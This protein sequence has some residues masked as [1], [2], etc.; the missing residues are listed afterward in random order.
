MEIPVASPTPTALQFQPASFGATPTF[1][2]VTIPT[3]KGL[4]LKL[5]LTAVA[6]IVVIAVALK[7]FNKREG[8]DGEYT[9]G[10][11]IEGNRWG[12]T[13]E[14]AAPADWGTGTPVLDS[15]PPLGPAPSASP[16]GGSLTGAM[17]LAYADRAAP[18]GAQVQC[19]PISSVATD[20]LPK[21][22][23]ASD[24]Y[25]EYAP[26]ALKGQNFLDASRYIGANTVG[27]SLKLSSYDIRST[28]PNPKGNA[29]GNI[30]L[31]T[32]EPDLFR[33]PLE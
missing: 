22:E 14:V 18:T 33:R 13:G 26:R 8:F 30:N 23:T 10:P 11:M 5:I 32:V 27:G 20:L 4:N 31:S 29:L 15:I 7:M 16:E 25:G 9:V 12:G 19:N 6:V 21:P 17:D 1:G 2:G 3:E 28:I 24:D